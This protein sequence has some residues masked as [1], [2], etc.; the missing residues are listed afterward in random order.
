MFLSINFL[1][2]FLVKLGGTFYSFQWDILLLE[3]GW[4]TALC[5]APW[6]RHR[7]ANSSSNIGKWPIRFLLFK[8]MFMSGVVKIQSECPTWLNLT[9]LEYHF[10]TQCL[11][12]PLS[13]YAHQLPPL[14]LRFAVAITLFIEIPISLLLIAPIELWR[15]MGAKLQIL[16][17]ITI[18]LTGNYNFFNL[19]TIALCIPCFEKSPSVEDCALKRKVSNFSVSEC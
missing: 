7:D 19:L 14:L 2:S 5:Y 10:A 12:S 1:Y 3:A 17:Q 16:L 13:W 11:P 18:I 9:A 8:L 15:K 4:I 6:K